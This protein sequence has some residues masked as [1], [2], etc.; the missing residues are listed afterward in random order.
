MNFAHQGDQL[1]A[2]WY[3]YEQ[4]NLGRSN[5]PLWLSALM[6]RQGTTNVFT[7]PLKRTSGPRFDNYK[8]SDVVQ[9]IPTVGTATATFTDGNHATFAYTIDGT[10]GL[11]V[12]ANQSKSITRYLF[13][14]PAGTTCH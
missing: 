3:T 5:P 7:G 2:T 13:V 4:K 11:P 9:P 12:V 6:P 14:G 1:F 10:D 8:A